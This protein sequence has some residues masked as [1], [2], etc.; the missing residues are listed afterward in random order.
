MFFDGGLVNSM[1]VCCVRPHTQ[2]AGCCCV[3]DSA[4]ALAS[5]RLLPAAA[6]VLLHHIPAIMTTCLTLS[7]GHAPAAASASRRASVDGHSNGGTPGDH[8]DPREEA[9]AEAALAVALAADEDSLHCLVAELLKA[10]EDVTG[11][12]LGAARL[13]AAYAKA[14]RQ[15]LQQHVDDLMTVS[16][17]GQLGCSLCGPTPADGRWWWLQIMTADGIVQDIWTLMLQIHQHSLRCVV[18]QLPTS[19]LMM[20]NLSFDCSSG[21]ML[22]HLLFATEAKQQV[23]IV[24]L[25]QILRVGYVLVCDACRGQ[26]AYAC[27]V[28]RNPLPIYTLNPARHWNNCR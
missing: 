20:A 8:H 24:M 12:A 17:L 26:N 16:G 1:C 9:A 5:G 14:T 11:R 18:R 4:H 3:A 7:S 19:W 13:L 23:F 2:Q 10:L 21:C 6:S 22:M 28:T 27:Q 25:P 15:D